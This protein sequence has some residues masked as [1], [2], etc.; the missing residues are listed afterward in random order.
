MCVNRELLTGKK[1]HKGGGM[2]EDSPI[3][4]AVRPTSGWIFDSG[5][6]LRCCL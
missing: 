6:S 5:E 3:E 4:V 2:A 1:V